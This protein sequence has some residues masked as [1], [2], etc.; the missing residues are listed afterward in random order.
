MKRSIVWLAVL[1]L[2]YSPAR[3]AAQPP[4]APADQQPAAR[5]GDETDL[6]YLTVEGR[7][8]TPLGQRPL[9]P[10]QT[11]VSEPDAA[12]LM[13][14]VPGGNIVDNG[15]VS[16]QVQYRGLFGARMNVLVN[17]MPISSGG[18]NRMD[19]PLHYVPQP[20]L[21]S[22]EVTR[23]IAP[24]S[25]GGETLGGTVRATA[26]HSRFTNT[27]T[28][29]PGGDVTLNTRTV[30]EGVAGGGMVSLANQTH[31]MHLLGAVET[32]DDIDFGGGTV[33]ATEHD[34]TTWGAGYGLRTGDHELSLN[35]QYT[36]TRDTGNPA[37]PMDIEYI[38]TDL[39]QAGYRHEW[40][41]AEL[42]ARF[43]YSD[44][45]HRMTNYLMR[46][47]PDFNPRMPGPDSRVS[48]TRAE[49]AGYAFS[50][51][52]GALELGLDGH[53]AEHQMNIANPRAPMFFVTQFNNV[54]R[55]RHGIYAQWTGELT[56]RTVTELGLRY[57][58]L[59]TR[60]GEVDGTPAQT[61]APPRRL[62]DAFNAADRTRTDDNVDWTAVARH[63]V[64]ANLF[65]ETGLA[66]KTRSPDYLE[67]YVWLPVETSG[68]LGDGN[69]YVGDP[70]LEPEV[71]HQAEIAL[72]WERGQWQWAPRLFYRRVDDYIQGTPAAHP[73][74]IAVSSLNGDPTPLRFTNVDAELYGVELEQVWRITEHWRLDGMLSHL[75]G[76]R[77]DINDNLYR[78]APPNIRLALK[79]QL[80]DWTAAVQAVVYDRQDK[81]SQTIVL[82][83]PRT[84]NEAT[85]GYAV[86]DLHARWHPQHRPFTL[87][88]GVDN[89]LDRDYRDHLAGFNRVMQSD[90]A[91]GERLPGRGR[92]LYLRLTA[93]W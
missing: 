74:V 38:D 50:I 83:E 19:P 14:H 20:L 69:T 46:P 92:N 47:V 40:G 75:R 35:Y 70:E 82:N 80:A 52:R 53:A 68:G 31:R 37:L 55:N 7:R 22:L 63:R 90:V 36:D 51:H 67:R 17:G 41:D 48:H 3:A 43:Y 23:G 6:P 54:E 18:P 24:V 66:R 12:R 79:R 76:K 28:F 29:R 33:R 11:G 86:L 84:T 56:E 57:N 4:S 85:P 87:A 58:R 39:A 60:A 45:D 27:D 62:R 72:Q 32:G 5:A 61:M 49:A 81:L 59:E 1:I 21:E 42:N 15:P 2:A 71:S 25:S 78:I 65:V 26:K 77:R 73:D 30:D 10:E 93:T 44:V 89:L 64:N 9:T 88:F 8:L 16:G 34:R 91:V 13:R